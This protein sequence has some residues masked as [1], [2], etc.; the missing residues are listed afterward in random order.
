MASVDQAITTEIVRLDP[1]RVNRLP[2]RP[3]GTG[4]EV[5]IGPRYRLA[6][7]DYRRIR[8]RAE[9]VA[10]TSTLQGRKRR[11]VH[12]GGVHELHWSD[13]GRL[14]VLHI[15]GGRFR[16]AIYRGKTRLRTITLPRKTC[17]IDV[18]AGG[19]VVAGPP[20]G[21]AF[22]RPN[23]TWRR[24]LSPW[25]VLC[26]RPDGKAMLAAE[27]EGGEIAVLQPDGTA[28]VVG[29]VRAGNSVLRCQWVR[30]RI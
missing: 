16:L 12:R 3:I 25:R 23:G 6:Y 9:T 11:T 28:E 15:R 2:I 19:D 18:S 26:W 21:L 10:Y 20:T 14:F 1:R 24:T 4:S 17:G 22:L 7:S 8:G 29:Q 30:Q 27:D 13:D 5:A